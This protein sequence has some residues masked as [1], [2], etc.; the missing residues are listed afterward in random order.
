MKLQEVCTYN[1]YL[2]CFVGAQSSLSFA[3][4]AFKAKLMV[5]RSLKAWLHVFLY[6]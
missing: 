3:Q 6:D 1:Q 4:W 2:L 5:R